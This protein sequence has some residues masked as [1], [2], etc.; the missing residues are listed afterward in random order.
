MIE[1]FLGVFKLH[2]INFLT[3]K[4]RFIVSLLARDG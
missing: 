4:L 3:K 1:I 2:V